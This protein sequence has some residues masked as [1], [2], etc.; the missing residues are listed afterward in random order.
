[1]E[2]PVKKI[3]NLVSEYTEVNKAIRNHSMYNILLDFNSKS[4]RKYSELNLSHYIKEYG[5][6]ENLLNIMLDE[7]HT[8]FKSIEE[9]QYYSMECYQYIA[10]C[11][12]N[13]NDFSET[14]IENYIR[15][16]N[17]VLEIFNKYSK[18]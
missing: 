15:N 10:R 13:D 18:M 11:Y 17:M 5:S 9:E 7:G 16:L 6:I 4:F 3:I 8:I 12:N 14:N 1:M 2:C